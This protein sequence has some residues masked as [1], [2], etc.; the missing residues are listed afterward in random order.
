MKICI[1]ALL[2]LFLIL[3]ISSAHAS[4][5]DLWG[6]IS[7]LACSSGILG[8]IPCTSKLW[9]IRYC[10]QEF[11]NS[12]YGQRICEFNE[13]A[14]HDELLAKLEEKPS[15][16]TAT[17]NIDYLLFFL[18]VSGGILAVFFAALLLAFLS[19]RIKSVWAEKISGNLNIPEKLSPDDLVEIRAGLLAKEME[20]YH[21]QKRQERN[22]KDSE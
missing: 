17:K 5:Q 21:Q 2:G 4:S 10:Q 22:K 12:D 16:K 13:D 14:R 7:K 1:A 19:G 6:G 9:I 8:H 11:Q 20:E 3:P 15:D 18:S